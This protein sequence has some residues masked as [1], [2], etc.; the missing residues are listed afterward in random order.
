MRKLMSTAI[1]LV[2]SACTPP[3]TA[4]PAAGATTEAP[5]ETP[6]RDSDID[7][8]LLQEYPDAGEIKYALAWNDLDG[9]GVDEAIVYP[10]G[11]WFCGSGGCNT[12]VLKAAGPMWSKVADVSVARTPIGVL[13]S[14]SSGWKD[15][16]VAIG[17]GGAPSG[18]VVLRFDGKSYPGNAST[19][20][21]APADVAG[22]EL[23]S[24]QPE[25]RTA[26]PAA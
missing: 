17:G 25:I 16:T 7:H 20:P 23:L 24:E 3:A 9:D 21:A 11:P 19:A 18:T 14:S 4:E 6:S 1:F 2:L 22:T 12:L 5:T 26:K 13:E 10:I 8:F 15:L